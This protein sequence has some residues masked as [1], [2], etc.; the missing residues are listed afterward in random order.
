MTRAREAARL[1]GNNTFRLDS[2]NAVGFNST[3]P[4]A[5]F[6]INSG[7][8]VAGVVTATSFSGTVTNATN[9][10]VADE[11]SDTTCFPLFVTAATG[12]LAPKSGSNLTFNSNT[13]T[14][15][16]TNLTLSG[17]LTVQGT[18]TTIDTDLI[19]VD[20]VEVGAN[21][22]TVGLA[23]TQSGSGSII[24]AYDGSTEVFT[25]KDG[26]NI[27]V[28][29]NTPAFTTGGGL[30][31]ERAGV[32][33]IRLENT[34]NNKALEIIANSTGILF[35]SRGASATTTFA[36]GGNGK[37]VLD[38]SGR[39]GVGTNAPGNFNASGDDFVV[40]G[41][42]NIGMTLASLDSSSNT[43]YF[44]DSTTGTGEYTGFVEYIH[45][46]D[47]MRFATNATEALRID[48]SQ[49][50]L[51]GH[52][53]MVS[54]PNMDDLQIGDA[55]GNRGITVASATDGFG[56]LAFGDSTDGSGTDR[57]R[58]FIEYYHDDDSMRLG[59][60]STEK[61][62]INQYGTL[63]VGCNPNDLQDG[64]DAVQIGGNLMLNVDSTGAGAG[65]YMSNNVYRDR[66]DS[67]W[68]YINTDEASQYLQ[69]N[70][71]HIW[72]FAGSGTADAAI[73]WSEGFRLDSSGRL[74][75]GRT[76]SQNENIAGTGYANLVQ[77]EG[78]AIGAGLGVAN[79]A[80]AARINLTRDLDS[81][82]ITNGMTLGQ[83]SF[84]SESPTSVERARIQCNADFTNANERG[85][86]LKFYTS[87][88][89]SFTPS[90][91]LRITNTG[92]FLFNNGLI[93]ENGAVNS[94][95]RNGTQNIDLNSGMVHYITTN[96]TGTWKPNFM[97][98]NS[99]TGDVN[100]HMQTG[101]VISPTMIVAKGATSHYATTIQVDGSDVTPEWL[102][103]APTDGGGSG[104]F[105]V[106]S[107]T[108]IK[109]GDNAF[110]AFGSVST[111]E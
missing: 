110:K 83:I 95:A 107:Y 17:D 109:T 24:A 8:T 108:I 46:S 23:V 28:G 86:T 54:H 74:L 19:G 57:Y 87:A 15:E 32:A 70:G 96:S 39:I 48:S 85:G 61:L 5:M 100:D 91:R 93:R 82:S 38:S 50:L 7:L 103:G 59:T 34:S 22:S 77:I 71:E 106:Y 67:R 60:V 76:S 9:V 89:G 84:G 72:R 80:N 64:Y 45:G 104:T 88:D 26:G 6:D 98:T 47:A 66:T 13:G 73:S 14:L 21:N 31:V 27:G 56:T 49:R 20:K 10:T 40:S 25:I 51:I 90:E 18:T 75:I 4:D 35:D 42:G 3:T 94:T 62:R 44:A 16:A 81:D 52:D 12:D 36:L 102:G 97:M 111:Y 63:G 43:I 101:D 92:A 2:N 69:A 68:E 30:E 99:G 11:S 37:L 79:S 105:D 29:T 55:T 78:D 33:N 41:T 65:V 1:I 58:G 53:T